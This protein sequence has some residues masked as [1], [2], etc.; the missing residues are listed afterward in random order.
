MFSGVKFIDQILVV[1]LWIQRH[2][3]E[4]Q[5]VAIDFKFNLKV[6]YTTHVNAHVALTTENHSGLFILKFDESALDERIAST[7][8]FSVHFGAVTVLL[9]CVTSQKCISILSYES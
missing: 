2:K 6:Q 9:T 7:C 3:V 5:N 4:E 8:Q 1:H